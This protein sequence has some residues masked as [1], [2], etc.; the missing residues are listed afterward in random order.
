MSLVKSATLTPAKLAA[1]ARQSTGP[2]TPPGKRRIVLKALKHGRH[3]GGLRKNLVKADADAE[4]F[5]WIRARE[6]WQA[7]R[8]VREV[9]C[10]AWQAWRAGGQGGLRHG[11]RP[12]S[13]RRKGTGKLSSS[14]RQ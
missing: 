10:R 4:L 14:G 6:R 2:R 9:W 5:N 12:K 7:E 8:L 13:E 1:N 11:A 3:L